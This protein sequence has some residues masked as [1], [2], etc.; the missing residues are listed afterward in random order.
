MPP[1]WFSLLSFICIKSENKQP[2]LASFGTALNFFQTCAQILTC[3]DK[4]HRR[5]TLTTSLLLNLRHVVQSFENG[6]KFGFILE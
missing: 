2:Y 3:T 6:T 4:T 5:Q 1:L